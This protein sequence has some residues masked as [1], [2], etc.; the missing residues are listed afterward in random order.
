MEAKKSP[1]ANL[2]NKRILF[3]EIGL[4]V[5][6]AVVLLAFEWRKYDVAVVEMGAREVVEQME[7]IIINT[8]QEVK[9]PPP[10]PPPTTTVLN[11]VE[12]DVEIEDELIIDVEADEEME[13]EEYV[14]IE[15]E[16]EEVVEEEIF[17]VVEQQPEFPGG[18]KARL[19]YLAQNINYP[20]MARESNIQGTVYVTFVVE[21]NGKI[22]NVGIL[23]GIGGGCDEEAIRVVEAMPSWKPGKQRGRSVRVRFNMPIKFTLQ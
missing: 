5:T 4:I 16:E 10:K 9:P 8:K 23:R 14:P 1:K 20:Q 15:V 12:D 11:I 7:E 3:I 21:P 13:I 18:E 2:E 22:S 19:T 6:L 17:L